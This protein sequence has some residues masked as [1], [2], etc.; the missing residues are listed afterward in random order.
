MLNNRS[1]V[2]VVVLVALAL[3]TL[4][5]GTAVGTAPVSQSRQAQSNADRAA[6]MIDW[7]LQH[8]GSDYRD[9]VSDSSAAIKAQPKNNAAQRSEP[10]TPGWVYRYDSSSGKFHAQ[11]FDVTPTGPII[12][13]DI[14]LLQVPGAPTNGCGLSRIEP[15]C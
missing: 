5:F 2:L 9:D 11:H 13:E 3:V 1:F 10:I 4:I 12:D 14:E 8:G 6:N 7:F 15:D